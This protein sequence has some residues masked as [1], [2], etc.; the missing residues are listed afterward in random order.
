MLWELGW[1]GSSNL[2]GVP[3][4]RGL[5]PSKLNATPA[6]QA[7]TAEDARATALPAST[8][9]DAHRLHKQSLA[10]NYYLINLL[11]L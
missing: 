3:L 6:M 5:P 7:W 9:L 4:L 1:G 8:G 11:V 2:N 10:I